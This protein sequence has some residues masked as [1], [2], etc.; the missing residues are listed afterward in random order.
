MATS[1][2]NASGHRAHIRRAR[3]GDAALVAA[4]LFAHAAKPLL[5]PTRH[6]NGASRP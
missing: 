5:T 2:V 1:T 3:V 4:L 6:V